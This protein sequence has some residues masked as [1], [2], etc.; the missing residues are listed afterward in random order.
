MEGLNKVNSHRVEEGKIKKKLAES[1]GK[2]RVHIKDWF[3][4]IFT[5]FLT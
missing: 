4:P 2:W 3:K 1:G 5:L